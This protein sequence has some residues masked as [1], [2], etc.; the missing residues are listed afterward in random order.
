MSIGKKIKDFQNTD[1]YKWYTYGKD[2][3]ETRNTNIYL[4]EKKCYL[5][6][7]DSIKSNPYAANHLLPSGFF[8][9]IVD[10]KVSYLLGNGI[11][12]ED[13]TIDL[14]KYTT[15][16]NFDTLLYNLS[17]EASVKSKAYVYFYIDN[18]KLKMVRIPSEQLIPVYD[19]KGVLSKVIRYYEQ[20][21]NDKKVKTALVITPELIEEYRQIDSKKGYEIQNTY[22]HYYTYTEF[23][24]KLENTIPNSFGML[25]IIE[26][27]NNE[28]CKS[29]LYPI[30]PLIDV[31]DIVNSDFANNIDDM[32]DAF[33]TLKNYNGENLQEFMHDLKQI[34]AVP[35]GEDGEVEAHQLQIPTEARKEFL[36]L[37]D[38]NIYKFAMAVDTDKLVSSSLTNVAINASFANLDLKADKF[39]Q[40]ITSFINKLIAFISNYENKTYNP[41]FTLERS[42]IINKIE[43]STLAN[44]SKGVISERTRLSNDPRV[45]DVDLELK[46]IEQERQV[47]EI[48]EDT[49]E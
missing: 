11:K 48:P 4:R 7:Y 15:D 28:I 17:N 36:D 22:A 49:E 8:P 44:E 24:G 14:D 33:Y 42:M 34:K 27:K 23:N 47:I 35:V 19:D 18:G 37:T 9:Q 1:E 21:I 3:Y 43:L 20:D 6:T 25:P 31:Y 5:P 40:Q 30:K 29:D 39:E 12:F 10:Q 46:Q 16:N 2:Y 32:Q 13:E 41:K 26:L 45:T 38:K